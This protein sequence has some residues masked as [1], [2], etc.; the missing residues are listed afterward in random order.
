MNAKQVLSKCLSLVTPLMHKTRR[1][2]LFS[3][4][5]SSMNGASLSIT[6]LGREIESKAM[7]KHKIKRVDR[8]CSNTYLHRDIEFIYTRMTYLLANKW[9]QSLT[10]PHKKTN[11][12][13]EIGKI[14]RNIHGIW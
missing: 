8:L 10:N 5:E 3:S 9:G 6:G 7:E 13:N 2:S 4:I 11:R 12:N 14:I 1:Q